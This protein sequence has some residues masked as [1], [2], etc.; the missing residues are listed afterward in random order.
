[1][2]EIP[3]TSDAPT[4]KVNR[5][6][7]IVRSV[8]VGLGILLEGGLVVLAVYLY[9]IW[10]Q[11]PAHEE[12]CNLW[13]LLALAVVLVL[14]GIYK[15]YN[16][17]FNIS[18][19]NNKSCNLSCRSLAI[20]G[21]AWLLLLGP[22]LFQALLLTFFRLEG[23][24]LFLF[25]TDDWMECHHEIWDVLFC[26]R[27]PS[28]L[29]ALVCAGMWFLGVWRLCRG[30][31]GLALQ[32]S[33]L[34]EFWAR[35]LPWTCLL[36]PPAAV[37]LPLG[38][39]LLKRRWCQAGFAVAQLVVFGVSCWGFFETCLDGWWLFGLALLQVVLFALAVAGLPEVAPLRWCQALRPAAMALV[40]ATTM[41]VVS[42]RL[43]F[44]ARRHFVCLE[45]YAGVPLDCASVVE[46][47]T[48]G[49]RED[50]PELTEFCH[51]ELPELPSTKGEI[52]FGGAGEQPEVLS[53]EAQ[54]QVE[55]N[56]RQVLEAFLQ[57]EP[58]VLACR[59]SH[60]GPPIC[61]I[62][63]PECLSRFR[64][65]A[66]FYAKVMAE[67]PDD[68]VQIRRC[69]EAMLRLRE[70]M[71]VN[72]GR[73]ELYFLV[74]SGI[75]GIRLNALLAALTHAPL[76][77]EEW[78]ELVGE[79]QDWTVY[80]PMVVGLATA[81]V[82]DAWDWMSAA[83]HWAT[84]DMERTLDFRII[85]F[86]QLAPF[87]LS[88]QSA[89]EWRRGL[90]LLD[91]CAEFGPDTHAWVVEGLVSS[92]LDEEFRPLV[93]GLGFEAVANM[94]SRKERM[95]AMR[96]AAL[97]AWK[98]ID[99]H[100]RNGRFPRD[101]A[102]AGVDNWEYSDFGYAAMSASSDHAP[103]FRIFMDE[104]GEVKVEHWPN[105]TKNSIFVEYPVESLSY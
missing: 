88:V 97:L 54:R 33:G 3:V 68:W 73:D 63:S 86:Q 24:R 52:R 99:F 102:E 21:F 95:V 45:K 84:T 85:R 71:L 37:L 49:L 10:S 65:A 48:G 67:H 91:E 62:V 27:M 1:M 83:M 23:N 105:P 89:R 103:G 64:F 38:M 58:Q 90:E 13:L 12:F 104:G 28:L 57:V 82:E 87:L 9:D 74:A 81:K 36:F 100:R 39:H 41:L 18:Y 56:Y 40:V 16:K 80:Y 29:L 8:M 7:V 98:V 11:T 55:A 60:G 15:I 61:N 35:T 20:S 75:E 47:L 14:L 50:S 26:A 51:C 66:K 25:F 53:G 96:R 79:E 31:R 19:I 32:T 59:I 70:W 46:R 78:L 30:L 34:P 5:W 43:R 42:G 77:E 6:L 93:F 69:N 17:Y 22:L 76:P 92:G 101:L 94:L 2:K 72:V 44:L 4:G